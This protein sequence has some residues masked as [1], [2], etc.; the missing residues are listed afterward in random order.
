MGKKDKS[1]RLLSQTLFDPLTLYKAGIFFNIYEKQIPTDSEFSSLSTM[2][3]DQE[4]H[5][6]KCI[7]ES[8][9]AQQDMHVLRYFHLYNKHNLTKH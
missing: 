9:P 7:F 3:R 2:S 8:T 1:S 6:R 4:I 5:L